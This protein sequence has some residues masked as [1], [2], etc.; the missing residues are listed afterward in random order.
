MSTIIII[1]P[2]PTKPPGS[3]TLADYPDTSY[4]EVRALIDQAE[5]NG[6]PVRVVET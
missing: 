6:D 3:G 4:A 5:A 2:P 1:S